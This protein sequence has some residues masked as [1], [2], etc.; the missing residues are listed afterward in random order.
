[1]SARRL[2]LLLVVF[3]IFALPFAPAP[4]DVPPG[5]WVGVTGLWVCYD[6]SAKNGFSCPVGKA[7]GVRFYPDGGCPPTYCTPAV[8]SGLAGVSER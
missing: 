3:G 7:V 1:M 6:L 5:E 2:L 8:E 4:A